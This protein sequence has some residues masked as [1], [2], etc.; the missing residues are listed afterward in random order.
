MKG[1]EDLVDEHPFFRDLSPESQHL[2]AGCGKNV[3]FQ[4]GAYLTR[5]GEEASCFFL[6]RQGRVSIEL[7]K[8]AGGAAVIQSARDGDVV[9]IEWLFDA[10][11]NFDVRATETTRALHF[12]T[13]CL[14]RKCDDDPAFGYLMMKKF[15]TLLM[16]RLHATRL[17][18]LDLYGYGQP[19]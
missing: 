16:E 6:I 13:E 10:R 18:L 7:E 5:D 4:P 19:R 12:D 2:V 8:P 1:I 3:V 15:S 11:W 14:K 9:G 17:R